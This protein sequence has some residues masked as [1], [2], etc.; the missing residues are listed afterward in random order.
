MTA[1]GSNWEQVARR[2]RVVTLSSVVQLLIPSLILST[3]PRSTRGVSFHGGRAGFLLGC[4]LLVASSAVGW[5][6]WEATGIAGAALVFWLI[7]TAGVVMMVGSLWP[8]AFIKPICTK[9]RLLQIIEEHEAI[10][11]AGTESEE[12]VWASMRLRHSAESLK[13]E[14]D[15]AIC[16]FCPIPKRL[17]EH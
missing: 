8:L 17:Q 5:L 4:A 7:G 2:L 15:P 11:L 6:L 10:H 3:L 16:W 12:A 13:L 9:C 14:G 1:T